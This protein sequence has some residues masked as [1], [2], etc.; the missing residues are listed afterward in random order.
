MIERLTQSP[1]FKG[2]TAK[3][4]EEILSTTH[5]SFRSYHKDQLIV[6][7]DETVRYLYIIVEGRVIGEM[8]DFSGKIL[9]IEEMCAPMPIGHAFLFG[10]R[11][12]FP[13]NV[14]ALDSCKL[15]LIP[16]SDFL[17][18]MQR[19]TTI[20]CNYLNSISNRAQFLSNKLWF[21]SFR[22]IKEKIAQ[23][24]LALARSENRTTLL[25]PKTHRELAE[26][27][28]VTRPSLARVLAELE[29]E[30]IIAVNRR[31]VI[32]LNRNKLLDITR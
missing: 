14:V 28:G 23:Y 6:N 12:R 8:A 24:L 1:I 3:Q 4:L 25:L 18:L 7:R 22:S 32:I 19:N 2:L 15:L 30:G 13:V 29:Q 9:K 31:E 20:L 10:E 27:F 16:R 17:A 11:N 21:L 26:F 5:H